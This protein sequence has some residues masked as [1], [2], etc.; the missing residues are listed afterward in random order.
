[1]VRRRS[2]PCE[3]ARRVLFEMSTHQ[4]KWSNHWRE[5]FLGIVEFLKQ[6]DFNPPARERLLSKR[7]QG[8]SRF[9]RRRVSEAKVGKWFDEVF[10]R[11]LRPPMHQ[12]ANHHLFCNGLAARLG[13]TWRLVR[14]AFLRRELPFIW[15]LTARPFPNA[16]S[17]SPKGV[18]DTG[19]LR[20]F[21]LLG[22]AS[23]LLLKALREMIPRAQPP[24]VRD[25]RERSREQPSS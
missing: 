11:Q 13:R 22:P 20:R 23:L 25:G 7:V 1:V 21:P 15:M 3:V 14:A 5:A 10:G 18:T 9:R 6:L 2:A 17:E 8:D 24:R 4:S 12:R 16:P 19:F